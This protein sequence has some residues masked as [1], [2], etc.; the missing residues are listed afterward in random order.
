MRYQKGMSFF[1]L[2]FLLAILGVIVS[3]AV[4]IVPPYLDFLTISGA[5]LETIKQPRIALQSDEAILKKI[6]NQLSINNIKL[7]ELTEEKAITLSREDGTLTADIDYT[8]QKPV[9]TSETFEISLNLHFI[10]TLEADLGSE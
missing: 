7:K 9:F 3:L 5:T 4:K 6:D 1:G 2:A 8:L 10:N